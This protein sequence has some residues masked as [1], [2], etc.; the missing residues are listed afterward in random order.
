MNV[1]RNP[2]KIGLG[3]FQANDGTSS[4]TTALRW[5]KVLFA[6]FFIVNPPP[7]RRSRQIIERIVVW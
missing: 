2:P 3:L 4:L 6:S 5:A 7:R 1:P